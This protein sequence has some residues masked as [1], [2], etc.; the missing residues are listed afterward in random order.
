[1]AEG[2]RQAKAA[3]PAPPAARSTE[4]SAPTLARRA[5][6]GRGS[7]LLSRRI[8]PS[9]RVSQPHDPAEREADRVARAVVTMPAP[10]PDVTARSSPGV[11]R[12]PAAAK[13][14]DAAADPA[15]EAEVRAAATG[16]RPLPQKTRTFLEPRMRASFAGV[17]IHT[18]AQAS[19]LAAK[20][21]ASAFTFGSHIFFAG[22]AFDPDS[23][24][25][26]ELLAHELTHTIQQGETIQRKEDPD[27][28]R[29]TERTGRQ[30]SRFGV[31]DVLDYFA[32]AAN[33]IPGY[34]MFTILIGVN[35]INMSAVPATAANILRAIVEF[36]PGGFVITRV[37]DNYGVF[38]KVGAWIEGQLK[39]LG[40]TGAAIKAAIDTFLDS[41]SWRDIF[42]LGSVWDRAK[43]IFTGPISR[44]ISFAKS[45]FGE[46][47][48]F[49]REAVLRPLA[50]L[51]E[52][53]AGY[54]LLKAVLGFDPVTGEAVPRNAETLIGG[55]MKMIGQ[56]EIWQN[57]QR[58]KA[59]P[60]AWAWF[61]GALSGLMGLV[62]SIPA[63]F[64]AGLRS[65]E[66]MDFVV[67]PSA[68]I[69][70]GKVFG[71]FLVDFGRWALGTV[72]D[73]LKIIVEVVAPGVMPYIAKAAGAFNTIVRNPVRFVRTLV[74]A[75]ML[76]FRQFTANFLTHL[77]ASLIGWLTG[78]MAGSGIYIPSGFS[79][80]ELLKF[81]L[82]VLGLTWPNVRAKLVKATS[83]TLVKG[84]ETGF[85]LVRKL[86]TEGPA[87]AWQ[88]I[89]QS[90]TN[91][92]QMAIDAIMDFV[93]SKV[94]EA[95]VTKLLSMLSPAGAVI[96]AIIAIYNTI[97]FF[98]ERLSQIAQVAAG[99]IDSIATIAAGNI[100]PAANRVEQTM[101]TALTVVISFLARIA[102]LGKVSDA[103]LGLVAK[104]RAPVDKGLDTAVTWV[105][106]QA[107]KLG[108]L[109]IDKVTGKANRTEADL[110]RD[111]EKAKRELP[112]K[113]D[114]L[115]ASDPS[116]LKVRA[117]LAI[118]KLQYKLTDLKLAEAGG[119]GK[120]V[121]TINPTF[122]IGGGVVFDVGDAELIVLVNEVCTTTLK[123][124]PQMKQ[125]RAEMKA[126]IDAQAAAGGAG[127]ALLDA[128]NS[129]QK[130]A[131]ATLMAEN[132]GNQTMPKDVVVRAGTDAQG[133]PLMIEW[134]RFG[135]QKDPNRFVQP[136][137][138]KGSAYRT[139]VGKDGRER[140]GLLNALAKGPNA[141]AA[142][143]KGLQ[144]L[145]KGEQLT[146]DV[147]DAKKLAELDILFHGQEVARH[148][149]NAAF[150]LMA[151]DL[152]EQEKMDLAGVAAA[153]PAEPTG[154]LKAQEAVRNAARQGDTSAA[155]RNIRAAAEAKAIE[156]E[157]RKVKP[158]SSAAKKTREAGERDAGRADDVL[159]RSIAL[160]TTWIKS[161]IA[162]GKPPVTKTKPKFLKWIR[163][164]I[165][166]RLHKYIS[167]GE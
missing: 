26:L 22:G 44:I 23:Q 94:V 99:F 54:P 39:S 12:A 8:Q 21:G 118:W 32:D 64:M 160:I 102:G 59:I 134:K 45:L 18:D 131:L 95:A 76:G 36:L 87:A 74:S 72:L 9:L 70:I 97:M 116:K 41:L 123:Q 11:H 128:S 81:V 143:V 80:L 58:A 17:R 119:T 84:L 150:G 6:D 71:G 164:A 3:E 65:L 2:A 4:R 92:K 42:H 136:Y 43:A 37:L 121:A 106:E 103:V 111:I 145:G 148:P 117:K 38:D 56:E 142:T 122:D 27:A 104:V 156:Q 124:H 154:A 167:K 88:Q 16:G 40:I 141:D 133:N 165:R 125:A 100:G 158:S 90:L 149:E 55:F 151:R 85:D 109:L 139:K 126:T 52:G 1:V 135:P 79:L 5:S 60:R 48:R 113:V 29:V 110:K 91:L 14:G 77:K 93:K 47:L 112:G 75:A 86:V 144:Q 120:F 105:V 153:H 161:Q 69:K 7:T 130:L 66:I 28:V 146:P 83:E 15:V 10:P 50:A 62:R 35:P 140:E 115:L 132:A 33:A 157:T 73:L 152:V 31:S 49:V 127:K 34:R 51:A 30:A 96:Q 24:A 137:G 147:G 78:A 101:A 108:K 13:G 25:G 20:L 46:I 162:A 53:T 107:K 19:K 166:T 138:S 163:D 82:S 129:K 63:R 114:E 98:K 61:Q 68:F 159:Q 57:I 155:A 67:L 89:V